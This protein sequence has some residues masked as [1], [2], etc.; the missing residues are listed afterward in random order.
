MSLAVKRPAAMKTLKRKEKEVC[1]VSDD[2]SITKEDP[3]V[4]PDCIVCLALP[5]SK[6]IF[7]CCHGHMLCKPCYDKNLVLKSPP[8]CP[9]CRVTLDVLK[10]I[11][12]RFAE[13]A[14][15]KFI[16]K[17]P[18]AG[19]EKELQ[20]AD[21]ELHLERLCGQRVVECVYADIGC[22]EKLIFKDANSH[23]KICTYRAETGAKKVIRDAEEEIK[24]LKLEKAKLLSLLTRNAKDI[25]VREINVKPTDGKYATNFCTSRQWWKFSLSVNAVDKEVHWEITRDDDTVRGRSVNMNLAFLACPESKIQF[26]TIEFRVVLSSKNRSIWGVLPMSPETIQEAFFR[27]QAWNFRLVATDFSEPRERDRSLNFRSTEILL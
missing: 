14:A 13:A 19:C 7:Q 15:A 12:N 17:C 9:H 11:R 4:S 26:E 25:L 6:E 20:H 24:Q 27:G 21:L 5:C 16:T 22:K 23:Y 8:Q 3:P 10:P 1:V 18:N 2:E